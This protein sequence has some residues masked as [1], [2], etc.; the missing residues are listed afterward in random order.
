MCKFSFEMY[1]TRGQKHRTFHPKDERFHL[2]P[3]TSQREGGNDLRPQL[4]FA[5]W[6]TLSICLYG[7]SQWHPQYSYVSL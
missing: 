1:T 6:E 7:F 4:I 5:K 3:N 2:S